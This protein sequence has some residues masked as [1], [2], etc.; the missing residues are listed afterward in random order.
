MNNTVD[1]DKPVQILIQDIKTHFNF[2][3]NDQNSNDRHQKI[4]DTKKIKEI[5][6][7]FNS[8]VISK[9]ENPLCKNI[10]SHASEIIEFIL[11][12]LLNCLSSIDVVNIDKINSY[13]QKYEIIK[14]IRNNKEIS[15]TLIL[16]FVKF[17]NFVCLRNNISIPS[18]D[19][20]NIKELII[21][22]N[23]RIVE[24][25]EEEMKEKEKEKEKPNNKRKPSCKRKNQ[26]NKKLKE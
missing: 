1:L 8:V 16:I 3:N 13:L 4:I 12:N 10:K 21:Q 17:L 22:I 14:I 19:V 23:S 11:N 20:N 24:E 2:F 26:S 6:K 7:V 25:E 15:Q 18:K 9:P 5:F